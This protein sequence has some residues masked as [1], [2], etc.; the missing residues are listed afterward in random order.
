MSDALIAAV[1]S[2]HCLEINREISGNQRTFLPDGSW[3]SVRDSPSTL[4]RLLLILGQDSLRPD[5]CPRRVEQRLLLP[6][7]VLELH[8][9][10]PM[11][12]NLASRTFRSS[13]V[14]GDSV[15]SPRDP[16]LSLPFDI[17]RVMGRGTGDGGA[18]S[19]FEHHFAEQDPSGKH[20]GH[21][22]R[23]ESNFSTLV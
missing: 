21:L 17:T 23:F 18:V 5:L 20:V 9:S 15:V 6:T 2:A 4:V 8:Q 22:R 3:K 10:I 12:R 1:K 7:F 14:P 11:A 16:A 13:N 19:E